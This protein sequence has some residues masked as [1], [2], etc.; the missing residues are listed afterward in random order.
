MAIDRAS[1]WSVGRI[2]T[3]APEVRAVTRAGAPVARSSA[4]IDA[5]SAAT[6]ISTASASVAIVLAIRR[7]AN[8][9]TR[10]PNLRDIGCGARE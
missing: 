6:S 2:M 7:S 1:R 9:D 10:E 8:G 5:A 3:S 4:S